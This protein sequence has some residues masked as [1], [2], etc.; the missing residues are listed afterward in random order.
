MKIKY[1]FVLSVLA[2]MVSGVDIGRAAENPP[3]IVVSIQPLKA[4]ID[5]VITGVGEAENLI[6]PGVSPHDQRLK[7]S[8]MRRM[9]SADIVFWVGP[10]LE[11]T[12]QKPLGNLK[13]K[14]RV[15]QVMKIQGLHKKYVRKAGIW[16][17]SGSTGKA[18]YDPH[19]WLDPE[20][21]KTIIRAIARALGK[22]DPERIEIYRK[23]ADQA[24]KAIGEMDAE[25]KNILAPVRNIPFAVYHDAGQYF[26]TAYGLDNV[27]TITDAFENR[28]GTAGM[29]R[30]MGT[31]KTRNIACMLY[32]PGP[33]PQL[34]QTI[35]QSG[36]TMQI[37]AFDVIGSE[38]KPGIGFYEKMMTGLA[39][40][41]RACLSPKQ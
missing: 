20:N 31:L 7:P 9:V 21:A 35:Q 29:T 18:A 14:V 37:R 28:I 12:W 24:V 39:R 11:Q 34:L 36:I 4:L 1:V 25:I 22:T 6:N 33:V 15:V 3:R 32:E 41:V 13:D 30:F 40:T 27:G 26:E 16:D 19:V 17:G 10:E 38:V 2:L 8:D 5:Q 23:N